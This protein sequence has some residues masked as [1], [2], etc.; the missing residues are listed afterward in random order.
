MCGEL[1]GSRCPADVRAR[2][3]ESEM[4]DEERFS[5]LLGVMGAGDLWP[6]RGCWV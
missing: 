3:V 1:V 6:L 5:L 2:Q 4:T